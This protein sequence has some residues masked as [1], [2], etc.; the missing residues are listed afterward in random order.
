[1]CSWRNAFTRAIFT[2]TSRYVSRAP[3]R[4]QFVTQSIGRRIANVIAAS[5]ASRAKR[6]ATIPPS[7]AT[8]PRSATKPDVKSSFKASTS[9]V[10]RVM[11][12]PTGVRSKTAMSARW[13]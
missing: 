5:V 11:S 9:V 10:R 12:R 1:M 7:T 3:F 6:I 2:R 13:R 4:N 8:S